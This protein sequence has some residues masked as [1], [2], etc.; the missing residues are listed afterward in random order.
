METKSL[1]Y[2]IVGFFLGGL[3]VSIA[4]TTFDKPATDMSQ[5]TSRLESKTGDDY[6][7]AF[8]ANMTDHH[9]SAI[10]MSKL[11]AKNAKHDEIKQLSDD[12]VIAQEKEIN[13]MRQWQQA[14]GY[15]TYSSGHEMSH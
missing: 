13:K 14:W 15:P 3:L 9:Q 8:L 12:V 4:A 2:G 6:D 5:M 7:S 10:D 11:S 1:L